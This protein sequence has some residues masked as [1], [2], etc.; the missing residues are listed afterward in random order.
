MQ[1]YMI[2]FF[3]QPTGDDQSPLMLMSYKLLP[4]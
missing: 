4:V 2:Q 1:D 3:E